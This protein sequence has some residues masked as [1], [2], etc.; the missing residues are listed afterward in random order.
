MKLSSS[1]PIGRNISRRS[2][3]AASGLLSLIAATGCVPQPT[4]SGSSTAGALRMGW[5]GSA[6]RQ[7]A[8]TAFLKGFSDANPDIDLK[9]E[10]AEYAAYVDRLATQAA[11]KRLPDVLWAPESQFAT[12][13][14]QSTFLDLDG[15]DKG[16]IDYSAFGDSQL[17]SW[18]TNDGKLYSAVFNQINPII[19]INSGKF[20][21]LGLDI[22]N[23]ESWDWSD[24]GTLAREYSKAAGEGSFGLRHEAANQLHLTQWVRQQGAELFDKDGKI[25]FD[26]AVLGDWFAMWEGWIKDGSAMPAAVAGAV[27]VP[28]PQVANKIGMAFAQTNHFVENQAATKDELTLHLMPANKGA[29]AGYPFLWFSRICIAANTANPELA[30]RLI[31]YFINDPGIIATAGVVSGPPSNAKLRQQAMETAKAS[32][33]TDDIKVLDILERDISREMRPRAPFPNG[34]AGFFALATRTTENITS[35]GV[36]I[37]QAVKDL[38]TELQRSLDVA[39]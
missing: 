37:D 23:D 16:V 12:Y 20:A 8:Y 13:A 22:P 11:A 4:S 34:S 6:P 14:A 25:G 18:R 2:V 30:G 15:L 17:E 35:G 3:L 10:P 1:Q 31:N 28:Y 21:A 38:M 36:P 26:A 27:G 33:K 7:A 5:W 9:L 29:A 19:Q 24:L 39:K 32:G